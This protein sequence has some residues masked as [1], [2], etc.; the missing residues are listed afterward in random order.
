MS[1]GV[2]KPVTRLAAMS[3]RP[4]MRLLGLAVALILAAAIAGCGG[5]DGGP[6][7]PREDADAMLAT[8]SEIEDATASQNCD[9][10]QAATTTLRDQVNALE[11]E[12]GSEIYDALG[13]MVSRLD[14]ELNAECTETGTTDAEETTEPPETTDTVAPPTTTTTTTTEE[15]PPEEEEDGGDDG[16]PPVEPPGQG[17]EPPGQVP[18]APPGGGAPSGGIEEDE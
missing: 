9:E 10:A 11:G 16:G 15:P 3:G 8:A 4:G 13:Q 7:I 18:D 14:E 2:I 6:E 17:G 1:S 12:V 5:D